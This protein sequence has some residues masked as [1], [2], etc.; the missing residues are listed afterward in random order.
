MLTLWLQVAV[1]VLSVTFGIAALLIARGSHD[2]PEPHRKTWTTVA[3]AFLLGGASNVMQNAGA[4]WAFIAGPASSVWAEYLLWAPVGNHSRAFLRVAMAAA[5]LGVASIW[6]RARIQRREL[7]LLFGGAMFT[8]ALNGRGEGA[9]SAGVH[10]SS[11]AVLNTI[12]VSVI[13]PALFVGMVHSTMDRLLWAALGVYAVRQTLNVIS[14][15]AL[16]WLDVP[17]T[18]TPHPAHAQAIGVACYV[19]MIGIAVHR[20]QLAQRGLAVPSLL[21]PPAQR[22]FSTLG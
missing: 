8:G 7:L 18:W 21:E 12:E 6:I 9:I 14:F 10:F 16:A 22:K 17:G 20:L 3:L 1:S 19:I 4:V 2:F 13:L 15:S 5:L 11:V